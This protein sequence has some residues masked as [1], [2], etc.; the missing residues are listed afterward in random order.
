MPEAVS[1]TSAAAMTSRALQRDQMRRRADPCRPSRRE[2]ARPSARSRARR[3]PRDRGA[4]ACSHAA[5]AMNGAREA[6]HLA[7]PAARQHGEHAAC[8]RADRARAAASALSTLERNH[9][10]ERM[11]DELRVDAVLRVELR[12]E[13]QHAEHEVDGL[14]DRRDARLPPRPDLRAHVLHGLVCRRASAPPRRA[15]EVLR[16]DA[17]EHVGARALGCAR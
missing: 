8:R 10:G 1:T 9:V 15:I 6:R 17:D 3:R 16:V 7:A 14:A 2:T 11:A 5:V 12:L 4:R 13:R